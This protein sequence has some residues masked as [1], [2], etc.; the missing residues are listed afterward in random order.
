MN[1]PLLSVVGT[2]AIVLATI[3]ATPST[4]QIKRDKTPIRPTIPSANHNNLNVVFLE[5]ADRM[6]AAE[7]TDYQIVVGNVEFRRGGMHMYCDSAHYYDRD[8]CFEA[9][10]NVRMRQGDTL[11]I[12]ADELVYVDSLQLATLYANFGKS[13]TLRNRDVK[14]TTDMFTYDLAIDLGY[15]ETGGVL[16]DKQNRLSSL[17]GEYSPTTKDANFR[18]DV[19]LTSRSNKDTLEIFTESL[20]YN[21]ASHVAYLDD[22]STIHNGSGTIYTTNGVYNTETTQAD[23]YAKSTVVGKDGKKLTGDTLFYNRKTGIGRAIGNMILTDS[24][25]SMRLTGDFG[26]MD[27]TI[28]SAMVTGH[29][30]A[31]EYSSGD[32][33]YLHGDTIRTYRRLST[34]QI[35]QL[36]SVAIATIS[37]DSLKTIE[38]SALPKISIEVPDTVHYVVAYPRV[39]FYRHDIQGLCD[40][41]TA[42]STDS[43]IYMNRFPVVWS[44]NRQIFGDVINLHLNDSTVDRAILPQNGFAAELIED[45][46]YNQ[47]SG[48]RMEATFADR[49]LRHLHV[50]G[51]VLSVYYPEEKDSTFNKVFNIESSF[52]AADFKDNNIERMKLWSETNATATPLYLAKKSLLYLQGFKWYEQYRPTDPDDIFNFPD[53]LLELFATAPAE[54]KP[55]DKTSAKGSSP[56]HKMA[57]PDNFAAIK[58]EKEQSQ[59][60]ETP[61][62]NSPKGDK[63]DSDESTQSPDST[64]PTN[65]AEPT[66]SQSQL[67]D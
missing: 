10:G 48:K 4:A 3:L 42:V 11:F 21:T 9:Y 13:V 18:T 36:D 64:E 37:S 35:E 27:E 31:T 32:T 60:V 17:E 33:L 7:G 49:K 65:S 46:Y 53:D 2:I 41:L 39:K 34:K 59:A 58:A 50:S 14:L 8:A 12:D 61:D 63:T 66:I 19:H 57:N 23:L 51:N 62:N 38:P 45:I 40:S 52:L 47:L 5:K 44:D 22:E 56:A 26:F 30:R 6:S 24:V 1:K 54:V 67:S 15:Y 29:A 20:L 55:E 25:N 28:D 43:M 16:T